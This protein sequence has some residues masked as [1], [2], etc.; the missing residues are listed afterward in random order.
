MSLPRYSWIIRGL[1]NHAPPAAKGAALPGSSGHPTG[2]SRL[3][4]DSERPLGKETGIHNSVVSEKVGF[5]GSEH[6]GLGCLYNK[7]LAAGSAQRGENA[8]I[9]D[10]RFQPGKT[11]PNRRERAPPLTAKVKAMRHRPS[12]PEKLYCYLDFSLSSPMKH[13]MPGHLLICALI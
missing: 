6:P 8:E 9:S 10:P 3:G 1:R 11:Q 2:P 5:P 7:M 4:K 12:D 13:G